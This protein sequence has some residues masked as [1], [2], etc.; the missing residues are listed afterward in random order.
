MFLLLPMAWGIETWTQFLKNNHNFWQ[1]SAFIVAVIAGIWFLK[2]MCDW[3]FYPTWKVTK[4]D[5]VAARQW[6]KDHSFLPCDFPYRIETKDQKVYVLD[7][8]GV[9]RRQEDQKYIV[10]AGLTET[11]MVVTTNTGEEDRSSYDPNNTETVLGKFWVTWIGTDYAFLS[12][13]N[14]PMI[15]KL[16]R[17]NLR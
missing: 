10:P 3:F 14:D 5:R 15:H 1:V 9:L 7:E 11:Q 6:M 17:K 16:Y 2:A 13:H 8:E 12:E 4:K